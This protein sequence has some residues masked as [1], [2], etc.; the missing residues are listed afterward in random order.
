MSS[1]QVRTAVSLRK[2]TNT[3]GS[4]NF[5]EKSLVIVKAVFAIQASFIHVANHILITDAKKL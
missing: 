2:Q 3:L 5:S 1:V 4:E